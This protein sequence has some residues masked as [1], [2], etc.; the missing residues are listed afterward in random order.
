VLVNAS[1]GPVVDE[2]ALVEALREN[3]VFGA[4]LD[5][6]EDEPLLAPGLAELDNVIVVPHIAS[7]TMETR[8]KMGEIAAGNVIKVL[9]GA[10][11]DT[12]VNPDVLKMSAA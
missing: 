6:F 3:R 12:C 10:A 4:G 1:R 11:P 2:K 7:A 8:L 5:V 9:T